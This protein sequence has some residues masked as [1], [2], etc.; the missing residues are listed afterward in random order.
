[1]EGVND[2][3]YILLLQKNDKMDDILDKY[4]RVRH[5]IPETGA[6]PDDVGL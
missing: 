6:I 3:N 5:G 2:T 1:M 4:N